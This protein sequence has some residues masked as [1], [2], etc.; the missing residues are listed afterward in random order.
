MGI[1]HNPLTQ[2]ERLDSNQRPLEPHSSA[3]PGLRHAPQFLNLKNSFGKINKLKFTL[4][5]YQESN[6]FVVLF[7]VQ[8]YYLWGVQIYLQVYSH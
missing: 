8:I 3:L 4:P 1:E 7:F 6:E 5:A 2:S